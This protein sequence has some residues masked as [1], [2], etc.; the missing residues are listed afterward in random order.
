MPGLSQIA[1]AARSR[2][3]AMPRLPGRGIRTE[4]PELLMA[5]RL[6]G[7]AAA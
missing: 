4:T 1:S 5:M 2:A 3:V 7:A 6:R